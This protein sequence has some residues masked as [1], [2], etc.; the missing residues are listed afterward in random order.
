MPGY[1]LYGAEERDAI[2]EWFASSHGVM[3][4]HGFDHLRRGV[5]KVREFERAVGR[6]V[7]SAH[8][9]AVSSGTAALFVALR[10]LGV[11]PGDEVITQAFTFVATLEAMLAA[12]ATPVITEVDESLTMDPEDFERR[13]TPRTKAVIPVHMGG[14][15]ADMDAILAI[16]RR[17]HVMVV[18]DTCQAF[19][20]TY[21]GKHLG[22]L[23]TMGVFS[24]DFAKN[25]TTGEGGMVMTDDRTLYERARAIHDHGHE[26]HP[27]RP[28]GQDARSLPGFNFRLTEIQGVLGLTQLAKLPLILR[29]QRANKAALKAGLADRGLAFRRLHDAQGDV[30]DTLI[31]FLEDR[32]RA[33]AFAKALA[34][35]R[36]GTKNLPDALTW[37]YAGTWQHLFQGIPSLAH[38]ETRWPRTDELL[39]RAIALP[40]TVTM[41]EADRATVVAAVRQI[42]E[43]TLREEPA[44]SRPGPR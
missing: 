19:G 5:F 28:R 18:E 16:A 11:G 27:Q 31:F 39:H 38:P 21:R 26:Y 13:I 1:E 20:G 3:M 43:K 30:G 4:A 22:T 17:H 37:H 9:Q 40:V 23:G 36:L 44:G 12:G 35:R 24:F 34:R 15:S 29:C 25:I 2:M 32:Q 6:T 7:G 41:S 42:A 8:A 14:A 10:A 33:S